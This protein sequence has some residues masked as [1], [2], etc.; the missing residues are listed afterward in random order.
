MRMLIAAAIL[1][2]TLLQL[3]APVRA[4]D[5]VEDHER[6][7]RALEAGEIAPL[8]QILEEVAA[9]HQGTVV[10]IE[11]AQEDGRWVYEVELVAKDGR[12]LR[13]RIDAK[14]KQLLAEDDD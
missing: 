13:L 12:L 14:S 2:G 1:A 5:R 11:L 10:E 9:H 6:A 4:D 7:R 8:D 3:A